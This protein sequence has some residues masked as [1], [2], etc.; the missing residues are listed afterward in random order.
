MDVIDGVVFGLDDER[1]RGVGGDGDVRI[2]LK[3]CVFVPHVAGVKCDGEIRAAA[4]FVG[5][6]DGSVGAFIKVRASGGDEVAAGGEADDAN[7]VGRD[8]IIR[9]F[10]PDEGDGALGIFEG[11]RRFAVGAFFVIRD[12]IFQ[13][14]GGDALGIEPVADFG[15]FEIDGEDLVP[16]AGKDN[17]GDAGVFLLRRVDGHGGFG[18]VVNKVEWFTGD[19]VGLGFDIFRAGR[20]VGIGWGTGPNGNLGVADRRL[21]EIGLG[22][23]AAAGEQ[24]AGDD[25]K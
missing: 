12:A 16:A 10:G 18:D 20:G 7:P 23:G 3:G 9:G 25:E 21:P 15:A 14:H 17:D 8:A 1:G 6:I 4:L 5:G 13:Q 11:H 2:Q 22:V 19:E 24:E